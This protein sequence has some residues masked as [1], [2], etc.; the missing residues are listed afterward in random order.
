MFATYFDT[1]KQKNKMD[2]WMVRFMI[3][4]NEMLHILGGI[5]WV[6]PVKFLQLF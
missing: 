1:H 2:C 5:L 6:F 3:R 4:H